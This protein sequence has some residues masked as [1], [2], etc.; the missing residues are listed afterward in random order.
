MSN[1]FT[2]LSLGSPL[3]DQRLDLCDLYAFQAAWSPAA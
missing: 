1:H 2:G 3:G